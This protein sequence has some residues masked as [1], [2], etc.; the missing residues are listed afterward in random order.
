[1]TDAAH[2]VV[3]EPQLYDLPQVLEAYAPSP[4][5]NQPSSRLVSRP[6]N[7]TGH[8]YEEATRAYSQ[9][10]HS[11]LTGQRGAP[12]AAADLERQL[13]QITGFHPGPPKMSK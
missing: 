4:Q 6:S 10:V 12:E 11:V 9:A 8:S 7:L 3:G 13:I 1:M 2:P 5:L